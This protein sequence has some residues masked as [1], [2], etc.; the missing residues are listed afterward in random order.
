MWYFRKKKKKKTTQFD[1]SWTIIPFCSLLCYILIINIWCLNSC[2]LAKVVYCFLQWSFLVYIFT[3]FLKKK[4]YIY[5]FFTNNFPIIL[6]EVRWEIWI[7]FHID[8]IKRLIIWCELWDQ[9]IDL[10]QMAFR[11][12]GIQFVRSPTMI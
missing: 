11:L 12:I 4:I 9:I 2:A 5:I 1:I 10:L 7:I 8:W 6:F 3:N